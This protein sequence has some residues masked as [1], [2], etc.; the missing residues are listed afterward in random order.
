M[1]YLS[2]NNYLLSYYYMLVWCKVLADSCDANRAKSLNSRQGTLEF[3]L[4][5]PAHLV[6]P[7]D[8]YASGRL[9]TDLFSWLENRL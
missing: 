4:A 3:D 9:S 6:V 2:F 7:R 5:G 8:G 1:E